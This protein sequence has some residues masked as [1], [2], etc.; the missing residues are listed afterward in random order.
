MA[1][2]CFVAY[3]LFVDHRADVVDVAFS[4]GISLLV[5]LSLIRRE[6]IEIYSDQMVWRNTYFGITRSTSAPLAD[7]L[8]AEW[9]EGEPT[10]GGKRPDY[11]EFFLPTGSVKSCYGLTF[12]EF[13]QMREDIRT[14]YPELIHRWG[15]SS[16]RS[17]DLTLLNLG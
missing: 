4:A 17:K 15:R 9:S 8:G 1:W 12:E 7:I 6:R 11:V 3:K 14:M 2:T 16:V 5:L 10:R 13:D